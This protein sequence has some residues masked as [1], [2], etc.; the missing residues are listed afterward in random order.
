MEQYNLMMGLLISGLECPGKDMD[1]FLEPLVEELLA[2]CTGVKTFNAFSGKS[3]DLHAAVIW[4]V[5]DYPALST[6]SD[7]V[8]RG[9]YACVQ[10]DKNP[11]SRRIRK[12]I[13]YAGHRCF[14]PVNHPWRRQKCFDGQIEGHGKPEEFSTEELMQQLGRVKDVRPGKHPES[15]KRKREADGQC[16]KHVSFSR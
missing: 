10:C 5:H 2:L 14:L 1:V 11:C 7:R 12:K 6:L 16:W 3:F 13:C 9:Y 15:K 4:C 8:T